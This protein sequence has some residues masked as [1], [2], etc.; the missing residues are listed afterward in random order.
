[1]LS[2]TMDKINQRVK[3]IDTVCVSSLV[4]L[5]KS[6]LKLSL[7]LHDKQ[8]NMAVHVGQLSSNEL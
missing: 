1:M 4:L 6:V 5:P 7:V 3:P 8:A 2:K